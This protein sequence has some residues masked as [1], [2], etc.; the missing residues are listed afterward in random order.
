MYVLYTVR[1]KFLSSHIFLK[2]Y[3][4]KHENKKIQSIYFFMIGL[5][6][7]SKIFEFRGRRENLFRS[8]F[9]FYY[10][11]KNISFSV[12]NFP[13]WVFRVFAQHR[14]IITISDIIH[15]FQGTNT[16]KDRLHLSQR[17]QSF[18][19]TTGDS[20]NKKTFTQENTLT[21]TIKKRQRLIQFNS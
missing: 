14:K 6:T 21:I 20:N 7:V 12:V 2:S 16:S 9:F 8:I 4:S 18:K 15:I 17:C 13:K 19:A 3:S 5:G 1:E 10:G 11:K